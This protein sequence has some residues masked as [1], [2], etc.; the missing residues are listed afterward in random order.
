MA[1]RD[2]VQAPEFNPGA[3]TFSHYYAKLSPGCRRGDARIID[4]CLQGGV[5][6]A[7]VRPGR[8]PETYVVTVNYPVR[9]V[10]RLHL[11]M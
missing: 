10:V 8:Q 6:V 9:P 7:E 2:L 3:W 1:S 11:S 5:R 4:G